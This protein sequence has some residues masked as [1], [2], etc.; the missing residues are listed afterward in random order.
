MILEVLLGV[1]LTLIGVI[2]ID[3]VMIGFVIFVL[4][5]SLSTAN[6]IAWLKRPDAS[7]QS[8]MSSI[9]GIAKHSFAGM[10]GGS[11]PKKAATASSG[12][13]EMLAMLQAIGQMNKKQ[14]SK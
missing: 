14:E 5:R 7:G 12:P 9:I 1:F 11:A 13:M 4:K 3:I 8:I 10:M 6:V 2:V